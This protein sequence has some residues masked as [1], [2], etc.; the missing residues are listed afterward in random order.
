MFYRNGEPVEQYAPDESSPTS[1]FDSMKD[2]VMRKTIAVGRGP[3]ERLVVSN[4][5]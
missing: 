5:L 1:H 3:A 2:F 4:S